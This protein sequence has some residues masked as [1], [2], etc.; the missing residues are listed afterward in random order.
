MKKIFFYTIFLFIFSFKSVFSQGREIKKIFSVST[1]SVDAGDSCFIPRIYAL[2][3]CYGENCLCNEMVLACDS[4]YAFL[5]ENSSVCIA[6]IDHSDFRPIPMGNDVLT[7][8]IANRLKQEILKHGDIDSNRIIATGMA[9][10]Q[11]RIVTEEIHQ[12]YNFLPIG[13]VLDME[14]CKTLLTDFKN[15]EIAIDLNRRTVVKIIKK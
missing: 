9:D 15:S 5:K 7:Q 2:D 13:Q 1:H 4:I 11:P 14:F 8:L 3:C 6:I 12:Q 10:S